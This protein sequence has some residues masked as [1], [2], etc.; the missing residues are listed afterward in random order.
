MERYL[1]RND[2]EFEQKAAA[3]IGLY[4]N[5]PQHAAVFCVDEKTAIQALDRKGR[6][7]PLSPGRA[8]RHGFEYYLHGTLCLFAALDPQTGNVMGQTAA[9]HASAEFVGFLEEVVGSC[10]ADQPV[11]FFS[12][13]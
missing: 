9:R 3:I 2:P 10:A 12:T 6:R 11:P 1:T 8:E 4:L 7:L 5:P 13:I